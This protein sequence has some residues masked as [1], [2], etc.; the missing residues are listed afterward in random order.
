MARTQRPS[1]T[2]RLLDELTRVDR[3]RFLAGCELVQLASGETLATPGK[4]IHHVYFP[5]DCFVSLLTDMRSGSSLEV[6]LVG[7]EGMLGAPLA[8]GIGVSP[9]RAVVQGTG[10]AWRMTAAQFH[11]QMDIASTLRQGIH[12]YLYVGMIQL[13]QNAGC[14]RFHVVEQRLARWLLM[15]ADRTRSA[16][17]H[18]THELLAKALGVRRVGIT[19]AATALQKLGLI[20]YSRGNI[21]IRNRRGLE[22]ASC[23]CYHA[24]NETYDRVI[25]ARQRTGGKNRS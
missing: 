5:L 4:P 16:M 24:D 22:G 11:R 3:Q 13:G 6:A 17:F 7:N 25:G 19:K 14:T 23:G 12:R 21:T 15:T 10:S 2:N 20:S 8:L 18:M 9:V 1:H